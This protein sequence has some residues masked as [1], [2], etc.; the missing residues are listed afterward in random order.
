MPRPQFLDRLAVLLRFG[1][2]VFQAGWIVLK[3]PLSIVACIPGSND[4]QETRSLRSIL[5]LRSE[6]RAS[7]SLLRMRWC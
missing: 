7:S 2:S 4:E 3:G 5:S 1:F 6:N